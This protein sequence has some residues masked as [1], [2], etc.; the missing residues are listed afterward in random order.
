MLWYALGMLLGTHFVL[1]SRHFHKY[2][3]KDVA[4]IS[5]TVGVIMIARSAYML[6]TV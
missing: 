4:L 5:F 2:N 3:Q 6:T 1:E